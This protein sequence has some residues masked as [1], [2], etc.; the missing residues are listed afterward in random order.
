MYEIFF[1]N[2]WV[3]VLCPGYSALELSER[4]ALKIYLLTYLFCT[5]KPKN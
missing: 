4:W 3:I 5:L 1:V 2:F